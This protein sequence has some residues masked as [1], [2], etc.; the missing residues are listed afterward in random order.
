MYGFSSLSVNSKRH[1]KFIYS[2]A[3]NI[4]TY[5]QGELA[6]KDYEELIKLLNSSE[7]EKLKNYDTFST[8]S[9]EYT[10]QFDY[11][12]KSK[13]IKQFSL[14]SVTNELIAF[15]HKIPKMVVLENTEAFEINFGKPRSN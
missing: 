4:A 9:D 7:I 10:L 1:F 13:V 14:P 15:L 12:N 3:E 2:N 6:I 5:Q 8:H 11:D